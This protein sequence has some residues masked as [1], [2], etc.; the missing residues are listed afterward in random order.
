M[1]WSEPIDWA[2]PWL[3]DWRAVGQPWAQAAQTGARH[4]VSLAHVLN[5]QQQAVRSA[6][7]WPGATGGPTFVPQAQLPEGWAY[8]QFIFETRQVPTRE[9]LHDFF[10]ALCWVQFPATKRQMNHLQA[11]ALAAAQAASSPRGPRGPRGPLR[12][13]LTVLDENAA[14]LQAPEA[15]WHALRARRWHDVFV[16]HRALWAQARLVLFGHA[17]LEKLVQPY[18]SVTAHV[19]DVPVP[20]DVPALAVSPHAWDTWLHRQLQPERLVT[21]PFVPLPVLGVPGWCEANAHPDFYADPAVF[22]P[23]RGQP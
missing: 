10:N 23:A 21:K 11:Q 12:D 14:L 18:K 22:R 7:S 19:L 6:S 15:L 16:T 8:E 17:L 2:Q 3:D 1:H 9:G 20:L 5:V 13:A 4:G